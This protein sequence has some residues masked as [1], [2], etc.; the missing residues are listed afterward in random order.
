MLCSHVVHRCRTVGGELGLHNGLHSLEGFQDALV[1]ID[2]PAIALDFFQGSIGG[3]LGLHEV[4]E[5]LITGVLGK[6][7]IEQVCQVAGAVAACPCVC[8]D[9]GLLG[10]L[11]DLLAHGDQFIGGTGQI[12]QTVAILLGNRGVHNDTNRPQIH[13]GGQYVHTAVE[14]LVLTVVVNIVL[15]HHV[16]VC[17]SLGLFLLVQTDGRLIP[18]IVGHIQQNCAFATHGLIGSFQQAFQIGCIQ[19]QV[20]VISVSTLT[21]FQ[22]RIIFLCHGDLQLDLVA[23]VGIHLV[24]LVSQGLQPLVAVAHGVVS[25]DCSI[26]L[27]HRAVLV[28]L[29]FDLV[30]AATAGKYAH[31]HQSGQSQGENSF[32][33]LHKCFLLINTIS[34]SHPAG[35]Q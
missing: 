20:H 14:T 32:H 8:I 19:V 18:N 10:G 25:N 2:L 9:T 34:I 27:L 23:L 3:G 30:S 13:A 31:N 11:R 16:A 24:E 22:S 7:F 33:H 21:N 26:D 17:H 12:I 4:Q 35:C 1:L 15:V 28:I 6:Q 29:N 5:I